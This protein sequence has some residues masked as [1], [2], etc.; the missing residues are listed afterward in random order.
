MKRTIRQFDREFYLSSACGEV[1][2]N[3]MKLESGVVTDLQIEKGDGSWG[4]AGG[5][6]RICKKETVI[7]GRRICKMGAVGVRD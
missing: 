6:R 7:V 3:G 5:R 1:A 2:R 4:D